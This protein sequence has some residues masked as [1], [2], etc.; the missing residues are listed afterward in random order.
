MSAHD[1]QQAIGAPE[2]W[3]TRATRSDD[4][5]T[6]PSR[7]LNRMTNLLQGLP[8]QGGPEEPLADMRARGPAMAAD[9]SENLEEAAPEIVACAPR[10]SPTPA[11]CGAPKTA[12]R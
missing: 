4:A 3:L 5:E 11:G 6:V 8:G 10:P 7:W 2:V 12:E 1:F 9:W